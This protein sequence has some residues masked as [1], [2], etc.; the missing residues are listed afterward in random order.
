MEAPGKEEKDIIYSHIFLC[1]YFESI[2][3]AQFLSCLHW[4]DSHPLIAQVISFQV[5]NLNATA[6]FHFL[7]FPDL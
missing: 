1:T 2:L 6:E 7:I 4:N 3:L 5:S